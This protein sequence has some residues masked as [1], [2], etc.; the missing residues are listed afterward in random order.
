MLEG[1]SKLLSRCAIVFENSQ[2]EVI[3][4][5]SSWKHG[6]THISSAGGHQ[7]HVISGTRVLPLWWG[8][9]PRILFCV[10][11]TSMPVSFPW[12]ARS[13]RPSV[14]SSVSQPSQ[15]QSSL[16]RS[17]VIPCLQNAQN[18]AEQTGSNPWAL[19]QQDTAKG[20]MRSHVWRPEENIW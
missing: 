19:F 9:T 10:S 12:T 2:W 20:F 7:C 5:C 6:K 4:T 18:P 13:G 16:S 11:F 17:Q 8:S 1:K 14:V 15:D 3:P